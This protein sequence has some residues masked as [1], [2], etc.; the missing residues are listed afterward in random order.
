MEILENQFLADYTTIKIGGRVRWMF[1]PENKEEVVESVAF[2]VKNRLPFFILAGGSNTI[3]PD[4]KLLYRQLVIN[5]TKMQDFQVYDDLNHSILELSPGLKLQKVVDLA[6]KL[7]LKGISSLNRIP[8]TVGGAVLGNAGAYGTEIGS[9]VLKVEYIDLV[10]LVAH[11][12]Y[13]GSQDTQDSLKI[14]DRKNCDFA[15]RQ[16]FFK[17]QS[18]LLITRIWLKLEKE[19]DFLAEIENYNQIALKR[20]SVYPVG[21]VSPG[22]VFKNIMVADLKP[23]VLAKIPSEW[24][25][26]GGKI[27]VAKLLESVGSKELRIGG[28][29]MRPS[30]ANIMIN[31]GG[32]VFAD[33]KNLIKT[34][35]TR[36]LEKFDI[37]IE[38]E[39]RLIEADFSK[40][41]H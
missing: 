4:E 38:P 34:L 36:V 17:N 3:F 10:K 39:I 33:V 5:L 18:N 20:D 2:A 1:F 26:Y 30:H 14:I 15:Y 7:K 25:V 35:Q 12:L 37:E 28:I 31:H 22:S 8:G 41:K 11:F 40:F 19:E 9:A 23:E 27:P 29:S 24:I 32:G 13:S 21:F 16:S 6:Q